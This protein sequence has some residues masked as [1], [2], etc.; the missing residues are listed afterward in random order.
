MKNISTLSFS[1][2]RRVA[3]AA[4][5]LGALG[6]YAQSTTAAPDRADASS[7]RH[8]NDDVARKDSHF[9]MKAAKGG[10]MEVELGQLAAQR[11][12]DPAVKAFGQRMVADHSKANQELMALAASKGITLKTDADKADHKEKKLSGKAGAD[13]D[14]AYV[15][16]MVDDHE[17]TV[18]L[19]E[20]EAKNGK[21]AEIRAF[22][23]KY[24]PTLRDHLE[25]VRALKKNVKD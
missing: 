21:D 10:M 12:Q 11:A 16:M 25:Q 5:A 14:E 9:V 4:L 3:L 2:L 22:A 1:A 19:F 17:D 6:A 18:R 24:L 23:E 13:F 8:D 20:K 7:M 15:K